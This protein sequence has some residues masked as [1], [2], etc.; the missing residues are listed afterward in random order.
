MES[1]AAKLSITSYLLS[2]DDRDNGLMQNW[3]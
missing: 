3:V 1:S 2:M